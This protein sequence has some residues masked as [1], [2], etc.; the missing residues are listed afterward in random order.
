VENFLRKIIEGDFQCRPVFKIDRKLNDRTCA[1]LARTSAPAWCFFNDLTA[2]HRR[3]IAEKAVPAL[4]S[5]VNQ[6]PFNVKNNAIIKA[7]T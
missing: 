1:Q 5:K 3:L 2:L 6:L 4:Q 7:G